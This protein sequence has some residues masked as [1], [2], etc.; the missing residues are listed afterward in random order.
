MRLTTLLVATVF[1][2]SCSNPSTSTLEK[3]K[4]L[5]LDSVD[6]KIETYYSSGYKPKAQTTLGILRESADFFEEHAGVSQTFSIAILDSAHWGMI[7]SLPYGLPFV[8]GPPYIV[9]LPADSKNILFNTVAPLIEGYDLETKYEMTHEEITDLFVSLIGFHE[10]GH[11]YAHSYGATFPNKWTFEFAATYF[12]YFYMDQNF[13][14][15][16]DIWMDV[17]RILITEI[18]PRHTSLKDFEAKYAGVGVEN[19]AWYQV[20]FLLQVEDL[21]KK[22]GQNFLNRLKS[23]TWSSGSTTEY[24]DEMDEIGSGFAQWAQKH[25]LYQVTHTVPKPL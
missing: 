7:S 14:R 20:A 12:A 10:L 5:N 21:Y 9:F 3:V 11:M 15:E 6:G 24:V 18:K 17:A 13:E 1:C 23:H 25:K 2:I 8:S 22:Q 19:Y 16:R 4:A